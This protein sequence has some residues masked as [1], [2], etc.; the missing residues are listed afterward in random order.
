MLKMESRSIHQ[1]EHDYIISNEGNQGNIVKIHRHI[2]SYK[3]NDHKPA[4]ESVLKELPAPV[5][6]K[7]IHLAVI[8]AEKEHR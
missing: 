1:K 6:C 8:C 2:N 7:R 5:V 3:R 4:Y